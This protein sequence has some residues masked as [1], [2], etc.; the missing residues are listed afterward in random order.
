MKKEKKVKR[1]ND[2]DHHRNDIST[3]ERLLVRDADLKTLT[4][5]IRLLSLLQS[6]NE[7]NKFLESLNSNIDST[8]GI[9]TRILENLDNFPFSALNPTHAQM[10]VPAQMQNIEST[11]LSRT[12]FP[13]AVTQ[14]IFY[15]YTPTTAFENTSMTRNASIRLHTDLQANRIANLFS[16]DAVTIGKD[17]FFARGKYDISNP[18]GIALILHELQHV[19]QQQTNQ[20]LTK[21]NKANNT[22]TSSSS[23]SIPASLSFSLEKEAL[24]TEKNVLMYFAFYEDY[25]RRY[26]IPS[27]LILLP[28]MNMSINSEMPTNY[29]YPTPKIG[30]YYSELH[31]LN[32]PFHSSMVNFYSDSRFG[33]GN[34]LDFSSYEMLMRNGLHNLK[35]WSLPLGGIDGSLNLVSSPIFGADSQTH[36]G[37]QNITADISRPSLDLIHKESTATPFLADSGRSLPRPGTVRQSPMSLT[38]SSPSTNASTNMQPILTSGSPNRSDFTADLDQLSDRIYQMIMEKIKIQREQR[39]FR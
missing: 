4:M 9:H 33:H 22:N 36:T 34:V 29:L 8:S 3:Q 32:N 23:G 26:K 20:D 6:I 19:R 10:Q 21:A 35:T 39:G 38:S 2:R 11:Y 15:H 30:Y 13:Q 17:I 7:N 25:I 14:L 12:Y 28:P 31:A 16:A 37:Y 18:Q 24:E 27:S 1:N 5:R